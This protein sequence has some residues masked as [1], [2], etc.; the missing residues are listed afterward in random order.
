MRMA[1]DDRLRE[2]ADFSGLMGDLL[3]GRPGEILR[4]EISDLREQIKKKLESLTI[5][6]YKA[7]SPEDVQEVAR[8]KGGFQFLMSLEHNLWDKL[9][10]GERAARDLA[11]RPK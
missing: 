3:M 7:L 2:L 4:K 11:E 10:S 6:S 8:L 9:K 5:L 1:S